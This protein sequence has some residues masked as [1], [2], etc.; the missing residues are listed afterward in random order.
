MDITIGV[1]HVDTPTHVYDKALARLVSADDVTGEVTIQDRRGQ[2]LARFSGPV[3]SQG[4]GVW[5]VGDVTISPLGGCGCGGTGI[6]EKVQSDAAS[7]V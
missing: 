5:T 1:A 7:P 3:Q 4:A 2:E 6:T